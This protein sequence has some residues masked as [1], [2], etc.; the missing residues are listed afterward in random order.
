L[1]VDEKQ[2]VFLVLHDFRESGFLRPYGQKTTNVSTDPSSRFWRKPVVFACSFP[3]T[4]VAQSR[5]RT[6]FPL[7]VSPENATSKRYTTRVVLSV[8]PNLGVLPMRFRNNFD[9]RVSNVRLVPFNCG[10]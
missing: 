9:F 4:A 5:I 8:N 6:G 3:L 10:F 2:S 7:G 1:G